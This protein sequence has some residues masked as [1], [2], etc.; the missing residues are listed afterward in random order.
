M[1]VEQSGEAV[2]EAPYLIRA[3]LN[4]GGQTLRLRLYYIV[5]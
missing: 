4:S 5:C 1:V 2:S 3:P